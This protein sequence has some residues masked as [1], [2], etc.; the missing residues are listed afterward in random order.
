VPV[1]GALVVGRVVAW[2]AYLIACLKVLPALRRRVAVRWER[3]A[4]LAR[5]GGWMTVSNVVSP[6]MTYLDRFLIGALL[7]ASA[8][9][10]YVTPY[11]LVTRL[12][13]VPSALMGVFFPAFAATFRRDRVRTAGLVDRSLRAMFV[14]L[15]PITLTVVALAGEGMTLWMGAEFAAHSMGVLRWLAAGVLINS[16]GQVPFALLQGAGRPDL[17]GKLHLAELPLYV[18]AIWALAGS[19]GI[20][21]VAIAWVLRVSV[22]TVVL[23]LLAAR[24]VPGVAAL[25]HAWKV[26]LAAGAVFAGVALPE[27][28]FVRLAVLGVVLSLF[29]AYAWRG[30]LEPGERASIRAHLSPVV[31]R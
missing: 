1:V 25:R 28:L 27:E 20:E 3:A 5:V 16:L 24:L 21:G 23:F 19:L 9:A 22:D 29:A 15:F 10:Y 14:I 13:L 31:G 17:T 7:S 11:E 8:V 4:D 2:A 30:I 12:W 6:L 18:A 26:T